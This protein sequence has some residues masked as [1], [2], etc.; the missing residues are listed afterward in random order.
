MALGKIKAD[1]LEHSTAGSV[2]TQFVVNGS[3]KAWSTFNAD[4][5]TPTS[6]D[7]LNVSSLTD[8]ATGTTT[9]NFTNSFTNTSYAT[10]A[11]NGGGGNKNAVY[12][13]TAASSVKIRTQ[14]MT[15]ASNADHEHVSSSHYG[16]LA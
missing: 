7:N 5:G 3:A 9:L 2:D 16:D 4:S 10:N 14:V 11:T 15:S 1:Q 13:D 6:L 12:Q 8:T